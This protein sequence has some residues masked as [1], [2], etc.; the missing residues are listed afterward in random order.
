MRV[1][2]FTGKGGVGKTSVAAATS[3]AAASRGARTLVMSTDPAHSLA[4]SFDLPLGSEPTP[5]AP[6][7][8]AM[9]I[10]S[11]Q[12]LEENW[13]EIQ[14]YAVDVLAWTGMSGIQAEELSVIPGLDELFSLADVKKFAESS[15]YDLLIVDCAP[16]A[17]TLRFLSLPEIMSWYIE[18]IFPVERKIINAVRPV[19]S[20][21]KSL[22][23][24]ASDGVFS[25]IER[26]YQRIEGVRE[27]LIDAQVTSIRL[28]MNAEKM[29]IAEARRTFT[30][31]SLFGYRVDAV[32]VNRLIPPSVE[33]PYFDGWKQVQA[34]HLDSIYESFSPVPILQAR[35]FDRE[36]VG[37]SLLRE[38]AAEVYAERD[39]A[40]IL[41]SDEV[42][43]VDAHDGGHRLSIRLPFAAGEAIDLAR[44]GDELLIKIGNFKRNVVLPQV[45]MREEVTG[46]RFDGDWLRVSFNQSN[47]QPK[48]AHGSN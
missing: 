1:V 28:V 40:A 15:E 12:R 46:A 17:E 48:V 21:M 11:Q 9:Q 18:K 34:E 25:A 2:L 44:S 19:L 27:I 13:R 6:N 32:V 23:P 29:V 45:V 30:Y 39:P 20:R 35:L 3:L 8:E 10:D 16:T 47:E 43:K 33:D 38:L 14:Q 7:L 31:L 24:I 41:F 36:M 42:I 37:V 26:F 22:P 4:D 5:V